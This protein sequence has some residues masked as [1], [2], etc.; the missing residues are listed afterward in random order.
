[1]LAELI[2][3]V[4]LLGGVVG[5]WLAGSAWRRREV[6]GATSFAIF[7][8]G[9]G[10]W[11]LTYA[12]VLASSDPSVTLALYDIVALLAMSAAY[13]WLFFVLEYTGRTEW[14]SGWRLVAFWSI[15]VANAVVYLTNSIHGLVLVDL[16][17]ESAAG[18]TFPVFEAGTGMLVQ[19]LS[20]YAALVLG[21]AL[22]GSF[23]FRSRNLYRTQTATI[24]AAVGFVVIVNFTWVGSIGW[25]GTI[26]P[27]P[28]GYALAGLVIWWSLFRYDF[29]DI[30]PLV[31]DTLIEAMEDPI[32]VI[33]DEGTLVDRNQRASEQFD[34]S[35]TDIG[36][37][38]PS[39]L[40]PAI[41]AAD[42][43]DVVRTPD[44]AVFHPA[45]TLLADH[46]DEVRGK[47]FVF[48]D[49][50]VQHRRA[51]RLQALLEGARDLIDAGSEVELA[52]ITI[53]TAE[54]VL[55][56][57]FAAVFCDADAESELALAAVTDDLAAAIDGQPRVTDGPIWGAYRDGAATRIGPATALP[58]A[59]G[60]AYPLGDRGVVVV[61]TPAG[62][63]SDDEE[64][65]AETLALTAAAALERT[66]NER[67]LEEKRAALEAR[68]EDLDAYASL[69]SHDLRNPLHTAAGYV[70]LLQAEIDA[71]ELETVAQLHDRMERLIDDAL[72]MAR[73]G[74]ESVHP[75]S[76]ALT[77][78]ADRAWESAGWAGGDLVVASEVT[79]EADPS[80]LQTA[81]ENLVRNA[82]E[83]AG[84]TA[85]VTVDA[86]PAT[87]RLV[88]DDDGPGIDPDDR[89]KVFERGV[90]TSRTGTGFGLSIVAQIASAHGW[91]L[92][93]SESPAGGA[94]FV[95]EDVAIHEPTDAADE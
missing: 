32:V 68:N 47:L 84:E 40:A 78:L 22:L 81:L 92:S 24:L 67:S 17:V 16:R 20:V 5:C 89:E 34:L 69:I 14:L 41:E 44:G 65:F 61:G 28:I 49:V 60:C 19:L 37:P 58:I 25:E 66:I 2:V 35:P 52:E 59:D 76:V 94:R 77:T 21:F 53:T 39:S 51:Q 85:T 13:A 82:Q 8:A 95:F 87:G 74:D 42:R 11:G 27:T 86:D 33:D 75:R 4:T 18:L 64:R 88:V 36:E 6:P 56:E 71:P 90:S 45:V 7:A 70:E 29:L 26:D 10:L 46:H 1:M 73:Y 50:T 23:L 80:Q 93:V 9:H 43:D 3:S 15:P 91:G 63:L 54:A 79:L 30:S 48:R 57:P 38:V 55:D 83:H 62:S 12:M 31:A 72:D